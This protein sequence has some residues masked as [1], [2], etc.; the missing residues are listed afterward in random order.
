MYCCIGVPS[1]GC[2]DLLS[3]GAMFD[4]QDMI[5]HVPFQ[6]DLALV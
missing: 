4:L 5:D 6:I 2:L 1:V 3:S